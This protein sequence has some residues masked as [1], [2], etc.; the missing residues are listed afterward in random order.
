MKRTKLGFLET[1]LLAG[2][3]LLLIGTPA[4]LAQM[5]GGVAPANQQ[6]SNGMD[7]SMPPSGGMPGQASPQG[8]QQQAVN[9]ISGNIRRNLQVET[10]LSKLALKHSS[11]DDIKKFAQKVISDDRMLG[12]RVGPPNGD[13]G[14]MFA[15]EVP[16]QTQKAEKQMKKLSGTQFDQIYLVQMDAY[17][18]DDQQIAQQVTAQPTGMA[19][20]PDMD[21]IGMRERNLGDER[22]QEI[23][24]LA[25]GEN[26]KIQ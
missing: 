21:E 15:P 2:G 25:A 24:Q 26:F 16:S 20:S 3:I 23:T 14:M 8:G 11:N 18:K 6:N 22:A 4:V 19:G 7:S 13:D 1:G 9:Q 17:V 12:E 5:Q 10:D